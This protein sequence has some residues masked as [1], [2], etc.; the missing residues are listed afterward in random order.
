M[1]FRELEKVLTF[2]ETGQ[3]RRYHTL[4]TEPQSLADHCYGM[5]ATLLALHPDASANLMAAIV[6]HDMP[7]RWSGDSP[8]PFLVANGDVRYHVHKGQR[9]YS[10][11]LGTRRYFDALTDEEKLWLW[12]LDKVDTVLL[13]FERARRG[14]LSLKRPAAVASKVLIDKQ[15]ELP[16]PLF[17]LII[18]MGT[19][20]P[21]EEEAVFPPAWETAKQLAERLG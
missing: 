16:K 19:L 15:Q 12:G 17:G 21:G 2:R 10:R 6:E 9:E 7:E 18:S 4:P 13:H 5:L 14:D 1:S 11:A 20:R 8:S 3:V